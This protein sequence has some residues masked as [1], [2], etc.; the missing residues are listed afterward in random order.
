[1]IV[2]MSQ[3]FLA[4]LF[5]IVGAPHPFGGFRLAG[6]WNLIPPDLVRCRLSQQLDGPLMMTGQATHTEKP[7]FP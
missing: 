2:L 7:E 6:P 1:V 3:R 5:L 4:C